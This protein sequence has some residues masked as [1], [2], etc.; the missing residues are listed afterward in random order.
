LHVGVPAEQVQGVG[1]RGRGGL[2]SGQQEDEHL[3]ADLGVGQRAFPVPRV[4]QQPQQVVAPVAVGSAAG[5]D[6]AAGA[7]QFLACAP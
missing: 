2:V 7:V 1:Q 5:D 6:L 4:E 3:L